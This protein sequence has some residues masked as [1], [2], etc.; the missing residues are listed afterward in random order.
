LKNYQQA[1]SRQ[2]ELLGGVA[3]AGKAARNV[4]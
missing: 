3:P 2:Q 4:A 1:R